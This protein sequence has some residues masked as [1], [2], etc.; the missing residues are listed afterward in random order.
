MK[1]AIKAW[2]AEN[3]RFIKLQ[4]NNN[5]SGI[6]EDCISDC[7]A[8]IWPKWITIII[9]E[10]TPLIDSSF[11]WVLMPSGRVDMMRFNDYQKF[12]GGRDYWQDLAGNDYSLDGTKYMEIV[13][14]EPPSS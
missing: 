3:D 9:G 5:L 1:A 4:E 13:K 11:Y 6:I 2:L 10:D 14:P 12:G 8:D 7:L